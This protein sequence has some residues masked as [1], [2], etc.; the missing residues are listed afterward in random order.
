MQYHYYLYGM[1]VTA[2]LDFVQLDPVRLPEDDRDFGREKVRIRAMDEEEEAQFR[3]EHGD[4]V[5][6]SFLGTEKGWLCNRTLA[7]SVERGQVIRYHIRK[8]G[9]PG[10]VR[11]YLLGFGIAMLSIQQGKLPIHCSALAT[12][13]GGAILIAGESGAGKSTLMN[14]LCRFYDVTDGEVLVDGVNVKKLDLYQLRD[15]IGIAMQDVFLFSDTIEGNIAYGRPDCSLEDVVKVAKIADADGFIR[16]MPD[17]YDTIVGERGMGLSGGQKQRISLARA[18]L[19]DP[20]IVILDDTT[21]AVDM[22]TESYIQ[23]E[24][25]S[26]GEGRTMFVIAYRISSVKDADLI[27][28]MDEGRIVEQGT[29][30]SLL[31]QDG[32][33]ATVFHHQYGE[34]EQLKAMG[35]I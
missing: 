6:G 5:C 22:E 9:D 33:Y 28:V 27:L 17:G 1:R 11:T 14:L 23:E 32:Y 30:E 20:P 21:S 25:K 29:H 31:A 16:Q 2:D 26:T 15:N 10:A 8:G 4:C 3:K 18:L 35:V 12:P 7:M 34:F 24:L 13:E 19:K